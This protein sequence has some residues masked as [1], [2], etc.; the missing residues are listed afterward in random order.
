MR[1]VG[2]MAW[3]DESMTLATQ[4]VDQGFDEHRLGI[5]IK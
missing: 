3:E 1:Y 2:A 5:S 4:N